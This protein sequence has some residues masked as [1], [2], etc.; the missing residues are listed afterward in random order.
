ML[1]QRRR[2]AGLESRA[3]CGGGAEQTGAAEQAVLKLGSLAIL[4]R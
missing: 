1:D 4:T 3:G 2:A